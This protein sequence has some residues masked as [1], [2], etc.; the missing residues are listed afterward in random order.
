MEG[1]GV[2]CSLNLA[3]AARRGG[4]LCLT[5]VAGVWI[6]DGFLAFLLFAE[7][8]VKKI[9]ITTVGVLLVGGLAGGLL[10]AGDT[11]PG[12]AIRADYRPEQV[13]VTVN[14]HPI[15]MGDLQKPLMEAYGLKILLYQVQLDLAKQWAEQMQI[16][17]TQAD[18]DAELLRTEKT[19]FPEAT[20]E[21]YPGLLDQL[22]EKKGTSRAEFDMVL[23]TNAILRKIAEPM[24]AGKI[25]DENVNE[26]FNVLYGETVSIKHIQCANP[27][28]ALAARTRLA[29]DEKFETVVRAMSHN[30]RSRDLDGELPPFSRQTVNWGSGWGKVP[31]GFKDWAF[32]AKVGEISDP[33]QA[34][35]ADGTERGYH[36]L[37][38]EKRLAPKAVK[39]T[40]ELKASLKGDLEERLMQQGINELRG[41]LAGMARQTMVI[42]EP[43]LKKQFEAKISEQ[44]KAAQASEN[45]RHDVIS[46]MKPTTLPSTPFYDPAIKSS[47]PSPIGPQGTSAIPA[48]GSVASPT[49][50][51]TGERPP[52]TKSA[53][54]DKPAK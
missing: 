38:L 32:S 37:K 7:T 4:W 9:I 24:L 34:D 26:A 25:T 54:A 44:S 53:S 29:S 8:P 47:I 52:A 18:F 12:E 16:S 49:D 48:A 35:S 2:N 28:E 6:L 27:Q 41:K 15:T 43:T 14:K 22:L 23:Q 30:A 36:I 50:A 10:R 19:G 33:I 20:K 46:K 3:R 40:P 42:E 1:I 17:V 21:E 31:Q 13:V 5:W 11:K 51:S 45:A 39:L